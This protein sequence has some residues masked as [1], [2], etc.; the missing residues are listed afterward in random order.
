MEGEV[1][2]PESGSSDLDAHQPLDDAKSSTTKSEKDEVVEV[3]HFQITSWNFDTESKTVA[4]LQPP[5]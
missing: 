1:H 5:F 3:K 4:D 2:A